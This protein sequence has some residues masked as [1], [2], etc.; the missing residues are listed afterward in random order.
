MSLR[1]PGW[2]YAAAVLALGLETAGAVWIKTAP[3]P[4][5]PDRVLT[6]LCTPRT[7]HHEPSISRMDI[8]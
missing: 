5:S 7:R 4:V 6:D 2:I 8:R 3:P 1:S